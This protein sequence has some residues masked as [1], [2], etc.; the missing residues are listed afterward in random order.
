MLT[1]KVFLR[2]TRRGNIIKVVREHY[3]RDD[4]WCGHPS[5]QLCDQEEENAKLSKKPKSIASIEKS[6][7]YLVLDTNVVLEQIDMLE[8]EGL[9]NVIILNTVLE[10]VRHRSSPIYKRL[11]DI[12]SNPDRHFYVFVNEHRKETYVEREPGE[13][14]ND[15][16][17]RAIRVSCAWF[18]EHWK[19]SSGAK[20]QG[21]VLL[22]DDRR[23]RELAVEEKLTAYSVAEYVASISEFPSLIDKIKKKE[24]SEDGFG[25]KFLFPEHLSQTQISAGVKGKKLFQGVFYLSRT[26][27]LEGTVNVEGK[28]PI[29]VQGLEAMNRAVDGDTVA[30]LLLDKAEWT[31]PL[32]VVLEDD[33]FDQGDTLDKDRKTIETSAKSKDIQLTGKVVGIVKRKWRQYCG[34]LQANPVKGAYRHIFVAAERK[35]PKVRIETRQADKLMGQRIIVAIDSW[36]RTSRYPLGH[37]VRALGKVGDKATENEVLLLE[38]DIPHS[39]FSEAVM[40]CLPQLPWEITRKVWYYISTT[41]LSPEHRRRVTRAQGVLNRPDKADED[42]VS[43]SDLSQSAPSTPDLG[44][45]DLSRLAATR[46]GLDAA[47]VNA[48]V[49]AMLSEM[50]AKLTVNGRVMCEIKAAIASLTV[51]VDRLTENDK[52]HDIVLQQLVNRQASGKWC[53]FCKTATH[54]LSECKSKLLC[55][56]CFLDSHKQ[57]ACPLGGLDCS[58]CGMPTHSGLVHQVGDWPKIGMGK[59]NGARAKAHR[60]RLAA[61]KAAGMSTPIRICY[62]NCNGVASLCKQQEI[63]DAMEGGQ[64][65]LLFVDETHLKRGSNEDMTLIDPWNPIYLERGMGLKKGGGKLV[66]RSERLNCL[67]WNPEV[68]GSEWISSERVWILVHNN[69]CKIAIC[70][71]YMAAEVT[72]NN[73]YIAWNDCIYEALQGEVRSRTEDGYLCM[74]IGDM[75]AHV[76]TPPDGIEGNRPGTNTN[77]EKLLNF[78]RNNNLLMLNQDKELCSGLFTRITP[79]SSTVLDYVLVSRALKNSI[80]RMII[81]EQ[82]QW[83][84]GSDHVAVYVEV[85]LPDTKEHIE[86]PKKKG[87]FLK[88]DRD[89]GLAHRIMDRH[90][91]E[92]DWDSLPLDE[93]LVNVQQI[94]V[95]SNVEAYGTRQAKGVKHKNRKLKR[96][97]QERRRVAQVER[98]LS[99]AKI[100]KMLNGIVWDEC[101]QTLLAKAVTENADLGDEIR[102]Q[103]MVIQ[104]RLAKSGRLKDSYTSDRFWRLAKRVTKNKGHFSA[105]KAPDGR[106]VTEFN[107]LK[108]LVVTELAKMSLGMKSKIFTTRGEQLVKEV[109][110]KSATNNEKWIPKEREEFAYE[111]EVCCPTNEREVREV[112]R[113]LKLDRAA[114]VDNVSSAMLKGASPTM[115]TLITGI[116]NESL[117]EGKVPGALQTGKMTLIDKKEP[118]LEVSKKRPIT[119]SSV[120]LSIITKIIHKRMNKICEREGFYGSVQYGFRQKRSTTDCVLMILA[121]LRV[122]KRKKQCISLAFCDIAKAYDSVCRELLYTKLRH[123]GFG[124]T[125][126]GIVG[127]HIADVSHFIRPNT[128]IDLEAADRCT[129]VYLTDRRIDMVPELLSGNLCSLRGGVE[130]FSFSC[131]WEMTPDAQIKSTKFHKSIIK[132][133][134]A[135]T[136][137]AAQNRIDNPEDTSNIAASLRILLALSKKLKE[138]RVGNGALVLASSEVRFSVD[139]ETA[140][141]IDV[142]AKVVRETNS[143]VE[144]FMLAA[145]ISAA[146]RIYRDFPDCAILRRHPAPPPSN[147]DPLVKAAKQQGFEINLETGKQLADSL[148]AAADP[149]R[150]YLNTMLRM[151]ATRC[152][153]QAVYFAS[154]T[155]EEPLFRHYGLACPIYTHFTS[156]IRRYADVMVH[157][158]LAVSIQADA[159][160]ANLVDKK[161][162]QKIAEQINYRHRMAQY[163]GRASVNLY[164]HIFFRGRVRDETG[165]ILY[166][167]QNAVQVLIPKYGLEGTLFLCGKNKDTSVWRFDEDEP[168]VQ[169]ADVKLSL[170]QK[171]IVQVSLDSSDIQHEKL[172]LKLVSPV[173]KDFSVPPAPVISEKDDLELAVSAA[174]DENKMVSPSK[175]R[176]SDESVSS[177]K[178]S[179]K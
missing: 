23:N 100:N 36:P 79:L 160:Y 56:V 52:N 15:R 137:E 123:I 55:D 28:D 42:Q 144:E 118:S 151:I 169:N 61:A 96:L 68:E 126:R 93:K 75:N 173:I 69:N 60:L 16:N 89:I 92:I 63:A 6:P 85:I 133:R 105:L 116:I 37:F 147:F 135:M 130:R 25:K 171:L 155:I 120:M 145:N 10:E 114:G 143:M 47:A 88:K 162:T 66:L 86:L 18:L 70:S 107:E 119:V 136:Y 156:P 176:K 134:E 163:A 148:N 44:M 38:H 30:V 175:K 158:L 179:K 150:P 67:V 129:T 117:M 57:G 132:S 131:V 40:E 101:D 48:P 157:R 121:A 106:L 94:L 72:A 2:K 31:A 178:K 33:G 103:R 122:A 17:D 54:M 142:Q 22:S 110:V 112:I 65:D 172:S 125:F 139:S 177:S 35:I 111:E 104:D 170:F 159:T 165:Y 4:I 71:V 59:Q 34:M 78:V 146:E 95:S 102:K 81:D 24:G 46:A 73:E 124:G 128:A 62:W 11:K 98:R 87:L 152:M 12:I 9:N 83:F 29:L 153:M 99:V 20:G 141:P 127:V 39:S 1:Q 41:D 53:S 43:S 7:H 74:I 8:S 3:L 167:R 108:D 19:E 50:M 90:I 97:Q 168:S 51:K 113:S 91:N 115:I 77:G 140:D 138:R 27:F 84:S 58:V 49:L 164:T 82:L 26:S 32:E 149:K 13:S 5:C 14:A 166:I 174:A 64:I 161:S 109:R 21:V 76:G 45:E 154:G 80:A